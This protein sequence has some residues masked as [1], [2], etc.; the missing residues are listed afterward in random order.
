MVFSP[1]PKAE[2]ADTNVGGAASD[3][4]TILRANLHNDTP[5]PGVELYPYVMCRRKDG[6]VTNDDISEES[7]TAIDEG[8]YVKCIWLRSLGSKKVNTCS[9][10]PER[11][12]TIQCVTCLKLLKKARE[13]NLNLNSTKSKNNA[14]QS[15]A[16]NSNS[17][18]QTPSSN[19]S[20]G[21]SVCPEVG[22]Y[23]SNG[24]SNN[25]FTNNAASL[26]SSGGIARSFHCSPSCFANAWGRHKA[27]HAQAMAECTQ[28]IQ[29]SI[30][31]GS[32]H[33]DSD[34]ISV[35]SNDHGWS[36]P[37]KPTPTV[38]AQPA[39]PPPNTPSI[40]H[41]GGGNERDELEGWEEVCRG[42]SYTPSHDDVG[43]TLRFECCIINS[44]TGLSVGSPIRIDT[45]RVISI[46]SPPNRG[47][48]KIIP[49]GPSVGSF[50]VL[51][52]NV[53]A[54]LYANQDM[55]TYC[56]A[57]ALSWSYRKQNLIRELVSYDADIMCLQ[58]VQSDH[59]DDV[60]VNELKN[61]GYSHV[62]KKKTSE[63]FTGSTYAI[64][65]C[66]TFFKKNKFAQVK[67]YEV[68]FNKAAL[69]LSEALQ[70]QSQKKA[71]L[72]R[73]MKDNVALIVVLEALDAP[74]TSLT[75][76]AN[77]SQGTQKRQLIC[78]AN[79]HIH[80]NQELKDVKLWQV[81][82]LLKGLE[83]IAA[84]AD[85]PMLV[86]GDFN[87]I[88]G[89]APHSLLSTGRVDPNHPD[90]SSD[91]LNILKPSSK[92]CH[93]LPLVSGMLILRSKG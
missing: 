61:H 20:Q 59:F 26:L 15:P 13:H 78:L 89:S 86:C 62:F 31:E 70:A 51:T 1:I 22:T 44:N 49:N 24:S 56:P 77:A 57:W 90:L 33:A 81:H 32:G 48:I 25:F 23:S 47:R 39:T 60:F 17:A 76:S 43:H 19:N 73:L 71:A 27:D 9:V 42:R 37:Q 64:D 67:K 75:P 85:I 30:V 79:T 83:K 72:N 66:A 53:L 46:P 80:A 6:N 5:I 18:G 87:S 2:K 28:H 16:P 63:V 54:D 10:H 93:H 29:N 84:S 14:S 40:Q 74:D 52:Y 34:T 55:Y 35:S 4:L 3:T 45:A 58:E 69:S 41:A 21:Q 7:Q 92:L 8:H 12:A 38:P 50:T 88:P 36:R 65:G 82:T 11:K 91:P 68:E